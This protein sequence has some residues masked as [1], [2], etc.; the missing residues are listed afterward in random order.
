MLEQNDP[1]REWTSLDETRFCTLCERTITGRDIR[2]SNGS[3]KP[4]RLSCPTPG[5]AGTP[6]EW[7]HLGDPLLS[8]EAYREWEQLTA[9]AAKEDNLSSRFS[10]LHLKS[11]LFPGTDKTGAGKAPAARPQRD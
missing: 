8:E 7:V 10:R 5:C 4:V 11:F 3:E 9:A 1:F 6:Y 2:V